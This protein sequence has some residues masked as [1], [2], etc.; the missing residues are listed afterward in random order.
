MARLTSALFVSAL[1]R[2]VANAGGS[3]VVARRGA[4]EAGAIYISHWNAETRTYTLYEPQSSFDDTQTLIGGRCFR[5]HPTAFLDGE[6]SQ[7]FEA[8]ARF[9]P[10]FWL[11]DIDQ[12]PLEI[13][14]C[15]S[16]V[17]GGE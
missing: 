3:A 16:V 4:G 5:A 8:E 11:V 14:E 2:R 10:D 13:S 1:I 15:I 17:S 6:L 9:D 7:R 12:L